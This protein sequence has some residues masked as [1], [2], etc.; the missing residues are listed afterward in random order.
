MTQLAPLVI[1]PGDLYRSV[2]GGLLANEPL[3]ME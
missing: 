1:S 2:W 3:V